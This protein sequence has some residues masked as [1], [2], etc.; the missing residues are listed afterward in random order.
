MGSLRIRP[1][2][3]ALGA[4][5][6]FF[7]CTGLLFIYS[8]SSVLSQQQYGS[9]YHFFSRQFIYACL[10]LVLMFGLGAQ[11]Y[12]R[13]RTVAGPLLFLSVLGLLLV[14]V[15]GLG[16]AVRGARRWIELGPFTL[17]PSEIV[18]VTLVVYLADLLAARRARKAVGSSLAGYLRVWAILLPVLALV[19]LQ[20]DLGTPITLGLVSAALLFIAGARPR[21]LVGT[22]LPAVPAA[23]LLCVGNH[24]WARLMAFL[25]PWADPYGTGYHL[26]QSFISLGKGGLF[27]VGLGN[28]TQK[29]FYLPDAHTDFIFA[30]MG[31]ELGLVGCWAFLLLFL[32]FLAIGIR[33]ALRAPDLFGAL[34]A[35]GLTFL[36]GI[37]MVLNVG[38]VLGL[39][40]TKG[41]TL[42][43]VSY[44]GSSLLSS[45]MAVGLL[46]SISR[47]GVLRAGPR[48]VR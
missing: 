7:V 11:D 18:K 22:V 10:G 24:R 8:T 31:E 47:E 4:L 33:V 45:L 19:L 9:Q 32:V 14:W 6:V 30:V 21:Y 38:V 37:Q 48:D 42:P 28:G 5:S 20:R 12:R 39:L 16:K 3:L 2:E 1:N 23:I 40:P 17:Q 27:G 15:P 43:F 44:G 41:M 13:L 35:S 34:L 29:L 36:L 26:V 46:I 25:D